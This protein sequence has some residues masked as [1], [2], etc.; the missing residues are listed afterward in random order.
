MQREIE[1]VREG[2]REGEGRREEAMIGLCEG[3]CRFGRRR[4]KFIL[5]EVVDKFIY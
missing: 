3:A 2:V 4:G 1:E 5:E